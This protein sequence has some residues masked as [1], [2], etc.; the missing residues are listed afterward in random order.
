MNTAKSPRQMSVEELREAIAYEKMMIEDCQR[1]IDW[2]KSH[3]FVV[4]A[5][6]IVLRNLSR[7]ALKELEEVLG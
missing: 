5:K 6:D 4:R 1:R 3:G 7:D 2:F